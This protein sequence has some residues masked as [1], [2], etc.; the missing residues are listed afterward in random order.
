MPIIKLKNYVCISSFFPPTNFQISKFVRG[1][2]MK[3]TAEK[4]PA[5]DKSLQ[6]NNELT[7]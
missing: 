5:S 2:K 3:T 6:K 4:M 1:F 7:F